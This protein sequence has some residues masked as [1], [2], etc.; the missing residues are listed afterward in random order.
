MKRIELKE[1]RSHL[2]GK[3]RYL[4]DLFN[5]GYEREDIIEELKINSRMYHRIWNK[6]VAKGKRYFK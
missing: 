4:W 6:V 5:L 2:I 3:E 1:F